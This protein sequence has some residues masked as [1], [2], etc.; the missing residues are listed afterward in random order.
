MDIGQK[1][2]EKVH[3]AEKH[4]VKHLTLSWVNCKE[5]GTMTG[6]KTKLS[7]SEIKVERV[8]I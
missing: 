5:V 2:L 7:L 1:T 3:N 6:Y 8:K 4:L